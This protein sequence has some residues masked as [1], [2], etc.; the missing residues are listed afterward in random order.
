MPISTD[1]HKGIMVLI[2]GLFSAMVWPL[3]KWV[4]PFC[5]SVALFKLTPFLSGMLNL[6]EIRLIFSGNYFIYKIFLH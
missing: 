4:N 5:Q 6:E 2:L 1:F 3:S